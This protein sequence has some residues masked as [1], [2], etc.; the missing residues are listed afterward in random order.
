M[1]VNRHQA[2]PGSHRPPGQ[3]LL[4]RLRHSTGLGREGG[5]TMAGGGK[6]DEDKVELR[7][8]TPAPTIV[9]QPSEFVRAW[10]DRTERLRLPV[11]DAPAI[12]GRTALKIRLAGMKLHAAVTGVVRAIWRERGLTGVELAPDAHSLRAARWLAA[13]AREEEVPSRERARRH[14]A[15]LPVTV[16]SGDPGTFTT[17]LNVSEGGCALRWSGELPGLGD[18]VRLRLGASMRASEARFVVRWVEAARPGR[19]GLELVSDPQ[20]SSAWARLLRDAGRR[21]RTT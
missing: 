19:V 21:R 5:E 20:G 8:D 9:M 10:S 13:A 3:G 14:L 4:S 17:T 15:E 2:A 12:G 11:T 7:A 16:T 1:A 18:E 6:R